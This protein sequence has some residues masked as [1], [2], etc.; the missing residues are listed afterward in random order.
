MPFVTWHSSIPIREWRKTS[1]TPFSRQSRAVDSM[2]THCGGKTT[3]TK[4]NGRRP[5][6][7]AYGRSPRLSAIVCDVSGV[8]NGSTVTV[9]ETATVVCVQI[10]YGDHPVLAHVIVIAPVCG[11]VQAGTARNDK[12]QLRHTFVTKN[13]ILAFPAAGARGF[14]K[15]LWAATART[16]NKTAG[17]RSPCEP[18]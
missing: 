4:P 13:P 16:A 5:G 2:T 7:A 17:H 12:D 11:I 3:G 14:V 8:L 10:V 6:I 9:P 18:R 1:L 15:L